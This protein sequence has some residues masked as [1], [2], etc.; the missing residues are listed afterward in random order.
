MKL[1]KSTGYVFEA[2]PEAGLSLLVDATTFQGVWYGAKSL[3][4]LP[5]RPIV[6]PDQVATVIH[7]SKIAHGFP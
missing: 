4:R 2:R 6:A 7:R 1:F 3:A 5:K